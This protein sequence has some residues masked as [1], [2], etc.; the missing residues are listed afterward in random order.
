MPLA[1]NALALLPLTSGDVTSPE[2][3]IAVRPML[4]GGALDYFPLDGR[5]KLSIGAGGALALVA[6]HGEPSGGF[7]GEKDSVNTA[8]WLLRLGFQGD[9]TRWLRAGTELMFGA[10][11]PRVAI[12]S[13]H[14]DVA[15]WGR[16]LGIAALVLEVGP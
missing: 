8:V 1:L 15:T 2:G 6:M 13:L 4:I 16:P 11:A 14:R 9:L 12:Q 7:V 3:R 10:S 5:F